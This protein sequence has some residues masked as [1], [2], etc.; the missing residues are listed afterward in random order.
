MSNFGETK[1][2]NGTVFKGEFIDGRRNGP[3]KVVFTDGR[4]YANEWVMGKEA[5]ERHW[6][7]GEPSKTA[8]LATPAA[9]PPA[10]SRA[11]PQTGTRM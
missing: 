11:H 10:S 1:F 3:G 7:M 5:G 4:S 6:V 2:A 8:A 9:V